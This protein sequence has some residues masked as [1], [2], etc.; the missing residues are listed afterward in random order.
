MVT[1][2]TLKTQTQIFPVAEARGFL[3]VLPMIDAKSDEL[4]GALDNYLSHLRVEMGYSGN[5]ISSYGTDL[6]SFLDYLIKSR[7]YELTGITK[8]L[9]IGYLGSLARAGLKPVT[10]ARKLSAIKGWLNYLHDERL[11]DGNPSFELKSP[12]ITRP[13]PKA[14][15]RK[16]VEAL[17]NFPDVGTPAGLTN[18]AMLEVLYAGGLRVSELLSLKP[19]QVHLEDGFLRILGKGSKER[20]VPL[21]EVAIVFLDRYL[22]EVRPGLAGPRSG[23]VVFLNQ[24]GAPITRNA[25]YRLISKM[26]SDAGLPPVSPHVLRHSFATHLLE[27]GADLRAV[28]MMLGHSSLASTELYLKVEDKRLQEVHSRF[29]PRSKE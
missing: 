6:K 14:L 24:K 22:K 4:F 3:G 17:I 15:D 20:L 2:T 9:L 23:Q 28:Q 5:T 16:Q 1:S 19:S 10:R 12:K 26:A 11:I 13:L 7:I 27:G 8:E 21:G 29:H 18:R 25:F